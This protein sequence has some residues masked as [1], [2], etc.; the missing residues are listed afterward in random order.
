MHTMAYFSFFSTKRFSN[1]KLFGGLN[2]LAAFVF[3]ILSLSFCLHKLFDC[4]NFRNKFLL[5]N[6]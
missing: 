6:S 4:E 2:V 5:P 3:I 1:F